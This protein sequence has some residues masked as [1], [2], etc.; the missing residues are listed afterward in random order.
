[1]A[2]LL[3]F[4]A[5][6]S[7]LTEELRKFPAEISKEMKKELRDLAKEVVL[8]TRPK[9]PARMQKGNK[10]YTWRFYGKQ[11]AV[12]EAQGA[13]KIHDNPKSWAGALEGGNSGTKGFRHPVWSGPSNRGSDRKKWHWGP[14][15][16]K[17]APRPILHETWAARRVEMQARSD[18]AINRALRR[19]GWQG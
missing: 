8:E 14:K 15:D 6:F 13:D 3:M 4:K 16:G 19:A 12:M 10:G 2:D 17:Q 1:M 7:N 18:A 11:G 9:M 5:D